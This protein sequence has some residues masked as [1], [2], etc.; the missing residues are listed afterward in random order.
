[1]SRVHI[2]AEAGVNYNGDVDTALR[3]I[4]AAKAAGADSVKFQ[5]INPEGL[6][7]PRILTNGNYEDNPA[8]P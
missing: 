7:L 3:L 5:M 8:V 1:M 4:D 2:I 6:Y